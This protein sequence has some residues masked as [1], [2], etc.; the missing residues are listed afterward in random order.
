ME[1]EG[2]ENLPL[3]EPFVIA[4]NHMSP[5][6]AA[7]LQCKLYEE[8]NQFT[9]QWVKGDYMAHGSIINWAFGGFGFIPILSKDYFINQI[10]RVGFDKDPR[11]FEG[12]KTVKKVL[13]GTM[14]VDDAM[15][16]H[17]D[18]ETKKELEPFLDNIGVIGDL[19]ERVNMKSGKLTYKAVE[20]GLIPIVFPSGTRSVRL[21]VGKPGLAQ[22]AL[23]SGYKVIPVAVSGN[24]YRLGYVPLPIP[25]MKVKCV[26]GEPVDISKFSIEEDFELFSR[27]SQRKYAHEFKGTTEAFM[28]AINV[29][30]EKPFQHRTLYR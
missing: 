12:F 26:I 16:A 21:G 25:G 27:E 23:H 5:F 7:P 15:K 2:M 19:H 9:T 20:K 29:R 10:Y 14:T 6:D 28:T 4:M 24:I 8:F 13:A 1:F 11:K 30:L 18:T 17:V 3:G 22:F